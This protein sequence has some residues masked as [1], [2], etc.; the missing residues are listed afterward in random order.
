MA[1]EVDVIVIE[2]LEYIPAEEPEGISPE[3]EARLNKLAMKG[4]KKAGQEIESSKTTVPGN[5][6]FTK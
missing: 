3:G 5:S 6:L 4:A 2:E 1:Q